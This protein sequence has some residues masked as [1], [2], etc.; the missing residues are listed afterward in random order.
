LGEQEQGVTAM[1]SASPKVLILAALCLVVGIYS[2][3][4][5]RQQSR[6]RTVATDAVNHVKKMNLAD[7]GLLIALDTISKNIEDPEE[8][9][10]PRTIEVSDKMMMEGKISFRITIDS[11]KSTIDLYPVLESESGHF[12]ATVLKSDT[13]VPQGYRKF[14]RGQYYVSVVNGQYENASSN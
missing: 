5:M 3:Q 13:T 11:S 4:L 12:R 7:A 6:A 2:I 9:A 10:I 14:H 1:P 8:K